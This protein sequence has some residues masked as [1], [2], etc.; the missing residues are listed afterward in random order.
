MSSNT[1]GFN[2][3]S[4]YQGHG[5]AHVIIIVILFFGLVLLGSSF[6]KDKPVNNS[7]VKND[8][9][10]IN[11]DQ[12]SSSDNY[13]INRDNINSNNINGNGV[14]NNSNVDNNEPKGNMF[15][16]YQG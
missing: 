16:Y 7:N 2:Y 8:N 11:V 1:N 13:D 12:N 4:D 3:Y 6:K 15:E 9:T 14:D 5:G 10:N